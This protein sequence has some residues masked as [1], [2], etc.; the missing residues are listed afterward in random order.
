MFIQ[1]SYQ[2]KKASTLCVALEYHSELSIGEDEE[3]ANR[4]TIKWDDFFV[5]YSKNRITQETIDLFVEMANEIGLKEAIKSQFTGDIINQTEGRAVL[6][7]ENL[8]RDIYR[9]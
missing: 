9:T 6:H 4:F 3:R 5:D 2:G 7:T 8:Q 1:R